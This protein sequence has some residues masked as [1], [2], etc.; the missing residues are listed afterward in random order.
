MIEDISAYIIKHIINMI[1]EEQ[2][3]EIVGEAVC[4][5]RYLSSIDRLTLRENFCLDVQ[6][7]IYPVFNFLPT[8]DF[9]K[10]FLSC[11]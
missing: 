10:R 4:I 9:R 11:R 2:Q 7:C 5:K 8:K 1:I 6:K 3:S